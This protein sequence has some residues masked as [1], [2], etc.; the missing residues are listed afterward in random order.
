[1]WGRPCDGDANTEGDGAGEL[2]EG[3]RGGDVARAAAHPAGKRSS[4]VRILVGIRVLNPV[5]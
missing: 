5:H 4:A 2:G 1:V 3:E